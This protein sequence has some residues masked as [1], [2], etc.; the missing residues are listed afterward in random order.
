M[1]DG[2][3]ILRLHSQ[4]SNGLPRVLACEVSFVSAS[5]SVVIDNLHGDLCRVET[6]VST[7]NV[8]LTEMFHFHLL[9]KDQCF[10]TELSSK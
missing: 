3:R 8:R 7:R 2:E 4:S 9:M 5:Q 1:S 10:K 6:V